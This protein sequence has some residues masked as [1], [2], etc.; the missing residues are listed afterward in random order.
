MNLKLIGLFLF[1]VGNN[2]YSQ[3]LIENPDF[4]IYDVCPNKFTTKFRKTIVPFW[5]SPSSG[6]L[7]YFNACSD[8]MLGVPEN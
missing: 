4:E 3:N 1:L 2:G 7:D 8:E 5:E 6:T